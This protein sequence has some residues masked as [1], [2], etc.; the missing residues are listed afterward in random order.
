M[1]PYLC[2]CEH[3]RRV[4]FLLTA[5][6]RMCVYVCARVLYH[7]FSVGIITLNVFSYSNRISL[8]VRVAR[9]L[10]ADRVGSLLTAYLGIMRAYARAR[11]YGIRRI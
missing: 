10:A 8:C 11:V 5:C 6:L 9:R 7:S 1:F 4:G 2:V 3:G